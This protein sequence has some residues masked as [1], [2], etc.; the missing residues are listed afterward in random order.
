MN[1]TKSEIHFLVI[2]DKIEKENWWANTP[3]KPQFVNLLVSAINYYMAA[4]NA[5][6][7]SSFA[8]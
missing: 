3:L 7:V 5:T 6:S 2:L 8:K 1:S 4:T